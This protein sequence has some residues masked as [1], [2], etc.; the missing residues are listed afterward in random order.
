MT[1]PARLT[2]TP[3]P[4]HTRVLTDVDDVLT[5]T[6]AVRR[7]LDLTRDVPRSVIESSID[8]ARQAPI[9]ENRDVCR[10]VVVQDPVLRAGVAGVYRRALEDFVLGPMRV[11]AASRPPSGPSRRRPEI[12]PQTAAVMTS[13]RYLAERL[14]DVPALILVGSVGR[15]PRDGVGAWASGFYGSVY[16][17]VWSLQLALRSRG[18]GSSLT[19]IHLH[20]AA[21][22]A[23]LLG[24]PDEFVQVALLPVAYTVGTDFK[25]ALR[26]PPRDE[27]VFWDRWS[28][29]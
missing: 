10:F 5:T 18:L 1:E 15:P 29:D 17:T 3:V 6:R 22:V 20:Y 26:R 19:C 27:V 11:K 9:A 16:P 7:R 21:A 25:P 24:L 4:P 8:I 13:G 23:E 2:P 14:Q 28:S 12:D